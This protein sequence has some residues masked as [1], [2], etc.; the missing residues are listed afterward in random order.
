VAEN[1]SNPYIL[2][3][4]DKKGIQTLLQP[5]YDNNNT[6]TGIEESNLSI[7][8]LSLKGGIQDNTELKGDINTL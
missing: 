1:T 2:I 8:I 5:I 3:H 4:E 6:L 7:K